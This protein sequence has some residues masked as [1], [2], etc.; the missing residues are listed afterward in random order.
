MNNCLQ[1]GDKVYQ[2]DNE[3]RIYESVIQS[4]EASTEHPIV[5]DCG[6]G[7]IAFDY[8]AI[9]ICVFLT[10]EDAINHFKKYNEVTE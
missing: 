2:H 9:G 5:Y 8:T 7:D 4:L 3:G 10:K 1:C 6:Y